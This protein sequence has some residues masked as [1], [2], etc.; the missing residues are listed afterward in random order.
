MKTHRRHT[1]DIRFFSPNGERKLA[2][3][4]ANAASV[5]R[6]TIISIISSFTS[7]DKRS[8]PRTALTAGSAN[9]EAPPRTRILETKETRGNKDGRDA[10]SFSWQF[11]WWVNMRVCAFADSA[12]I[13]LANWSTYFHAQVLLMSLG[14]YLLATMVFWCPTC[15]DL[16]KG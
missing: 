15:R 14:I 12:K 16:S 9:K 10:P 7:V 8:I 6:Q 4:S 11:P 2:Q 3:T 13:G 5:I 1:I